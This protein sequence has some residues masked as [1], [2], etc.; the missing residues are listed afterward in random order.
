MHPFKISVE[1]QAHGFWFTY[2]LLRNHYPYNRVEALWLIW[3]GWNVNRHID[4]LHDEC[5]GFIDAEEKA[6]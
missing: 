5:G 6:L 1:L 3:V 4:K 2:W